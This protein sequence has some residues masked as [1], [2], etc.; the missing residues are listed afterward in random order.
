MALRRRVKTASYR[1]VA[2]VLGVSGA[3]IHDILKRRRGI[4]E[5]LAGELGFEL[6]PPPKPKPRRWKK[7][8]PKSKEAA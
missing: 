7:T 2:E 1:K 3:Y 5:K 6:V 8:E 4:T